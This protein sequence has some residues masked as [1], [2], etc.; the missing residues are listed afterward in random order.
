MAP[1][2]DQETLFAAMAEG[3]TSPSSAARLQRLE[4]GLG[5]LGF[6]TLLG[7][8]TA[9]AAQLRGDPAVF[10]ALVAGALVT[11]TWTVHRRWRRLGARIDAEIARRRP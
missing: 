8:L 1:A 2:R 7:L 3:L 11:M 10:E 6:F 4:I 5:F 9:A